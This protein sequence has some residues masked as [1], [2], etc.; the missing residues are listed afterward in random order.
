MVAEGGEKVSLDE[1]N[2]IALGTLFMEVRWPEKALAVLSRSAEPLMPHY[3]DGLAAASLTLEVS[4]SLRLP[5]PQSLHTSQRT[6][7]ISQ[8]PDLRRT[9]ISLTRP[10]DMLTPELQPILS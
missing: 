4:V 7:S 5:L 6:P 3:Y 1:N 2:V 8:N 10:S 9:R